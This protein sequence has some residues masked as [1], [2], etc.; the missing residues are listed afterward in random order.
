MMKE[1]KYF[2]KKDTLERVKSII[3]DNGYSNVR[4]DE[5]TYYCFDVRDYLSPKESQ[6][7]LV[8]TFNNDKSKIIDLIEEYQGGMPCEKFDLNSLKDC[9]WIATRV[10]EIKSYFTM[11]DL[12]N[13]LNDAVSLNNAASLKL[14]NT[15][16]G[17]DIT[18]KNFL[19]SEINK[20]LRNL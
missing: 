14:M 12:I 5:L 9:S 8:E 3:E 16:P 15:I 7:A 18:V 17:E 6:R 10:F 4:V 2:T 19:L 20:K 13:S 1:Q 11:Q